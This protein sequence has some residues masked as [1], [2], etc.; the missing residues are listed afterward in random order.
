MVVRTDALV[1]PFVS[2]SPRKPLCRAKAP[3]NHNPRVGGSSPSSGM[4]SA[5]KPAFSSSPRSSAAAPRRSCRIADQPLHVAASRWN[6][7]SPVADGGGLPN[8]WLHEGEAMSTTRRIDRRAFIGVAA[9]RPA[10]LPW[11]RSDRPRRRARRRRPRRRRVPR[12]RI[13]LQQW[14]IRD[15]ITRLDG[16]VSG[17]LGGRTSR[18]TRPTWGRSCRCP[19]ASRPSSAT[20]RRWAT[21]AS[22]SSASTRAPTARSPTSRSGPR[23][24]APAW[25]PPAPTPAACSR[26]STP[27]TARRR[28]TGPAS[29]ATG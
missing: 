27:P 22:S 29:T 6:T 10:P 1:S 8:G 16:S 5:C 24:T 4:R 14:S 18:T 2:P 12:D 15:A 19:A 20:S 13:G 11:V 28:S 25:S 3:R 17:Y 7:L 23:S 21:A 9:G 26:W